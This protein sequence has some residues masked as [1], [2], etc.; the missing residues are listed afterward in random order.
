MAVPVTL[1]FDSVLTFGSRRTT[2]IGRSWIGNSRNFTIRHA[3][4]TLKTKLHNDIIT[5]YNL[6]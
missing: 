2:E 5:T 3:S 6:N 1:T 4:E